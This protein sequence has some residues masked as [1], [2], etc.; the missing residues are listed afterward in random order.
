MNL[1]KRQQ[2]RVLDPYSFLTVPDEE[3]KTNTIRFKIV[4]VRSF[5]FV[6]FSISVADPDPQRL[7]TSDP[8]PKLSPWIKPTGIKMQ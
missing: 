6:S 5:V 8:D 1:K 4:P 7:D 3:F 2:S